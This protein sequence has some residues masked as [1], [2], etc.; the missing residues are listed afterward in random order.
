MTND[1]ARQPPDVRST[2]PPNWKRIAE[3]SLLAK[4][5]SPRE[6]KRWNSAEL[7]TGTG[8]PS[9]IAAEMVQRPSPESETWPE[10]FSSVGSSSN[11]IA[12]RSSS[13]DATTLPRRHTSVTSAKLK[14]Y[15]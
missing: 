6:V 3:S 1:V 14:S 7:N 11:E 12:V 8:V 10:N 2:C 4:S 13:Q 15:W 5:L 9:S